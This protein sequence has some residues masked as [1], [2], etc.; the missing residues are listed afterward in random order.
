ME[1]N[2]N[3]PAPD[4]SGTKT[5]NPATDQADIREMPKTIYDGIAPITDGTQEPVVPQQSRWHLDD[6]IEGKGDRPEWLQGKFDK[7]TDQAKAYTD[8]QKKFGE[9]K[10][11]PENYDLEK[12]PSHIQKDS[13]LIQSYSKIFKEMNL[14]QEG[15]ERVVNEFV[16]VQE[17]FSEVKPE[18][19]LKE[20]GPTGND[21]LGRVGNW[22]KNNFSPEEQQRLQAWSM[23][24]KD[25]MLL[26]KLR[27]SA[28][29]SRAPS[30]NELQG[31]GYKYE[32]SKAVEAEKQ[33]NWDKYKSNPAYA[34][35]ISRRY[36]DALMRE[37]HTN[38][39]LRKR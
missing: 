2:T 25:V 26:D 16:K 35:E 1:S 21:I 36:Q 31:F 30:E 22:I 4:L 17:E 20:L 29:L 34:S 18:Q 27:A 12:L 28:P 32:T 10:G 38:N 13:P 37:G 33:A 11:A 15:F 7:V 5:P 24:A 6:G 23:E 39:G 9:F 8:L 3:A 19:I 14:S